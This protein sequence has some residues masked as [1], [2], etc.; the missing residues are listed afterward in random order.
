MK[1]IFAPIKGY[2]G[3]YEI[4]SYGRVKNVKRNSFV[5]PKLTKYGYYKVNLSKPCIIGEGHILKTFLI[6]RLVAMAFVPNP[7]SKEQ[8][9]HKNEN[10]TDNYFMN[11]EWATAKENSN[12]GTRNIRMALKKSVPVL[13]IETGQIFNSVKS[14][15]VF[16]NIKRSTLSACLTGKTKTAGGYCWKYAQEVKA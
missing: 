3:L 7:Q 2:E 15:A 16:A 1:E 11:L 12:Y 14:A 6:H 4:S 13:C 8:V 9:N 10:K 5:K